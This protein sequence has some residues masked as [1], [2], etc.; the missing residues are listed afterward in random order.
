[1]AGKTAPRHTSAEFID[2]LGDAIVPLAGTSK[3]LG[4][5]NTTSGLWMP[6][7][8]TNCASLGAS[9][10]LPSAAPP[11]TQA[12]K[13]VDLLAGQ[14]TVVAEFAKVRIGGKSVRRVRT[15]R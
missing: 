4:I 5:S 14:R 11:S 7:P 13:R 10:D 6:Q 3:A 9:A 2:F 15:P 1:M 8:S 12:K